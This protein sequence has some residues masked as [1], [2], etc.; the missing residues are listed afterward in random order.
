M[1]RKNLLQEK[2]AYERAI[3]KEKIVITSRKKN[4][5]KKRNKKKIKN[6]SK[7]IERRT[8]HRIKWEKPMREVVGHEGWRHRERIEWQSA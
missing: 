4:E 1:I 2:D 7:E 8:A 5:E 3:N 6:D